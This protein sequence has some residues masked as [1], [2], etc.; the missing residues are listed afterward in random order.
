MSEFLPVA[1]ESELEGIAGRA[2][3]LGGRRI[4]LFCAGGEYFALDDSCP[5]RGGSLSAGWVEEGKVYC[6]LHG[7]DFELRTGRCSTRPDSPARRHDVKVEE[8]TVFVRIADG[9]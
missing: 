4:A 2:F 7:W 6:P 5:H 1:R 8:G 9:E 3:E